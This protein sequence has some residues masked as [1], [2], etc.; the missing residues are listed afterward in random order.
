MTRSVDD[1]LGAYLLAKEGGVFLDAAGTE[2]CALPIVPLFETIDDLRAAPAIMREALSVPLIR[3]ST[4]WQGDVQ[5]VMIG[6]SDSNK[7]GGF[8]ASNWELAKAQSQ[9]T[10]VGAEHGRA[11]R[12]LPWPRRLGLPRRRADRPRHR[13]PARRLDQGALPRHRAGRGGLVQICQSA[14]PRSIRWSCSPRACS[15]MR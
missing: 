6:Y 12:L 9:L 13:R 5:E 8:V 15:S 2:I 1:I 11:D 14:A 7:D 4:H 10:K 3:R